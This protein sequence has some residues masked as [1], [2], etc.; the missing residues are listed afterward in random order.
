MSQA[1]KLLQG[2]VPPSVPTHFETDVNT[3]AIP[4]LNVLKVF[5]GTS[6]DDNTNGVQTDGSSG[7]NTLT[8]ELTNRMT[9]TQPTVNH[10]SFDVIKFDLGVAGGY[11]I[12]A[13]IVAYDAAANKSASWNIFA[14]ATTDAAT[15]TIE[16]VPIIKSCKNV[17][18]ATANAFLSVNANELWLTVEGVAGSTLKWFCRLEYT[19]T[20]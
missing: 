6:S 14:C 20:Q 15:A 16:N 3:D 4:V 2:S 5:G 9:V 7:S 8:V 13:D 12:N 19:R 1:G 17:A 18:L 10:T 11:N